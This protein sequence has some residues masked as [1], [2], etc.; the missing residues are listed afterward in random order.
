MAASRSNA[1]SA[2][3]AAGVAASSAAAASHA[4]AA[5]SASCSPAPVHQMDRIRTT[6]AR[7]VGEPS[8]AIS[9]EH[10][11]LVTF[12]FCDGFAPDSSLGKR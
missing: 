9:D 10:M 6:Q 11:V 2:G 4:P 1:G 3:A 5:H 8:R 12:L 7:A